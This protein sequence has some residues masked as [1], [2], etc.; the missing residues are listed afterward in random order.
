MTISLYGVQLTPGEEA[1]Y[2]ALRR[3]Q[4]AATAALTPAG[5]VVVD[6]TFEQTPAPSD[7][8]WK[9]YSGAMT[10]TP[11]TGT[12]YSSWSRDALSRDT[13]SPISGIASLK[14]TIP[15]EAWKQLSLLTPDDGSARVTCMVQD[16]AGNIYIGGTFTQ[17]GSIPA[18]NIAKWD[19]TTWSGLG[20]GLPGTISHPDGV[21]S[22]LWA[23]GLN[24]YAVGDFV[25]GD[26]APSNYIAKWTGSAWVAITG[27][28][29]RANAV[30]KVGSDIYVGSNYTPDAISYY[31]LLR[32]RAGAWTNL[33]RHNSPTAYAGVNGFLLKGSE[34]YVVGKWGGSSSNSVTNLITSAAISSQCVVKWNIT[35]DVTT[36][37]STGVAGPGLAARGA[38]SILD[39]GAGVIIAGEFYNT[40]ADPSAPYGYIVRWTG[41]VWEALHDGLAGTGFTT[42]ARGLV[43]GLAGELIVGNGLLIRSKALVGTTWTTSYT[44]NNGTMYCA[45]TTGGFVW[46]AGTFSGI[47]TTPGRI[48][49]LN[50]STLAGFADRP[51]YAPKYF[52]VKYEENGELYA[53][54][55]I[56][57]EDQTTSYGMGAWDGTKWVA[58]GGFPST[59]TSV[60]K[61][62]V[63]GAYKFLIYRETV[64]GQSRFVVGMWDGV[65][66]VTNL[67]MSNIGSTINDIAVVGGVLYV[68]GNFSSLGLAAN[69]LQKYNGTWSAV[70]TA[71]NN[72]VVYLHTDG[73]NLYAN[74]TFTAIGGVATNFGKFNGSTWSA[75]GT[76]SGTYEVRCAATVGSTTYF[77]GSF[78]TIG[79]VA[80]N[81]VVAYNG[82]TFSALGSGMDGF[83]NSMFVVGGELLCFGYFTTAGGGAA[84]SAAAWNGSTWRALGGGVLRTSGI[85]PTAIA[86][87]K[88]GVILS[89]YFT[90]TTT[91]PSVRGLA[92]LLN[93]AG[94]GFSYDFSVP[95][96]G[97]GTPHKVSFSYKTSGY[98]SHDMGVFLYCVDTQTYTQIPDYLLDAAAAAVTKYFWFTPT[99]LNYR[100]IFANQTNSVAGRSLWLDN[101]VIQSDA[102][103]AR[104]N[105]LTP[106]IV[107]AAGNIQPSFD[108]TEFVF[109]SAT[110]MTI[111]LSFLSGYDGA[112]MD[113]VNIGA[114][115][116]TLDPTGAETISGQATWPLSQYHALR[117]LVW[118]GNWYV[119]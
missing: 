68:G 7:L 56:I 112:V 8:L 51:A 41:S 97:L 80:Y 110:A 61:M 82:S 93:P 54:T 103:L 16:S 49:R 77:G 96:S 6:G 50:G 57:L 67:G 69:Y 65:N 116:V 107:T 98:T 33:I 9:V 17:L 87:S 118:Q 63:Y 105:R 88:F 95:S 70:G 76:T 117:L 66:P 31:I 24:I 43:R 53:F 37:L 36:G 44:V 79:G 26:G 90:G 81:R 119:I 35:T 115:V 22:G 59:V 89:G 113:F 62:I 5:N 94:S 111:G 34:L 86:T 74:G 20:V 28:S 14:D 13:V 42:I 39:D 85:A 38:I 52:Q 30:I 27:L 15:T 29:A 1:V 19:G 55:S 21:V 58:R 32:Y 47:S 101:V 78:T 83:V 45:M 60:V 40:V 99:Q 102:S 92:Q 10:A 48:I 104:S 12:G 71:P 25:A 109:S 106:F 2:N 3:Q 72:P 4:A 23:D 114:G 73:T 75:M 84:E 100:L 64:S 11:E 91:A 46:A 108:P 18:A